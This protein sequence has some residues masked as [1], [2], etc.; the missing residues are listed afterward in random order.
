ML[1]LTC[2]YKW[3]TNQLLP[4]LSDRRTVVDLKNSRPAGPTGHRDVDRQQLDKYVHVTGRSNCKRT[5]EL[6]PEVDIS[7]ELDKTGS[8][9]YRAHDVGLAS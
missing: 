2:L 5:V 1:L 3:L 6:S 4:E 7:R 9:V 8:L